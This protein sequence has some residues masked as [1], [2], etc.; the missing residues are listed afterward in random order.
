MPYD[1]RYNDRKLQR[2]A[3]VEEPLKFGSKLLPG[4]TVVGKPLG[5]LGRKASCKS[6][7]FGIGKAMAPTTIRNS[8]PNLYLSS[9]LFNISRWKDK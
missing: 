6:S 2:Y 3:E 7:S 9:I 5:R 4:I 1:M 8:Y